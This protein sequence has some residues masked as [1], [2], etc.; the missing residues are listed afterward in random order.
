MLSKVSQAILVSSFLLTQAPLVQGTTSSNQV[1]IFSLE[2]DGKEIPLLTTLE[3]LPRYFE[4]A[5][6]DKNSL[7]FPPEFEWPKSY[8]YELTYGQVTR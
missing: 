1:V 7:D 6:S 4:S 5:R 8:S 3:D 2:K